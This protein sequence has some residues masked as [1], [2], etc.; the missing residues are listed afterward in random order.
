VVPGRRVGRTLGFPTLN[1][2]WRSE[3]QPALGVYSVRVSTPEGEGIRDGVANFGMQ[4][5]VNAGESV[6]Q[7]EVHVLGDCPWDSGDR[8]K[9]E[10]QGFIRPERKFDSLEALREQIVLDVGVARKLRSGP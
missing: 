8:L 5:T 1:L 6:P 4:P 9:V 10:W 2:E 3:L 7:L